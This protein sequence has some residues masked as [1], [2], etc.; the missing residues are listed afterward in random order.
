M[1][2]GKV[3]RWLGKAGPPAIRETSRPSARRIAAERVWG[4][5]FYAPGGGDEIARLI[6]PMRLAL[7]QPFL[8]VSDGGAAVQDVIAADRKSVV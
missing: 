2:L 7:G 6:A 5:G 4:T 3:R 1:L 8:L